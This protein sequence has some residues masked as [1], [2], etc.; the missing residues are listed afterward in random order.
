MASEHTILASD[1]RVIERFV[2]SRGD[3]IEPLLQI[4]N[5]P[6][7]LL[8]NPRERISSPQ[9][10]ALLD[11]LARA[12]PESQLGL[13]LATFHRITDTHVLGITAIS[14][15]T[16]LGA[17]RRLS[18]YQA[19]ISTQQPLKLLENS[20]TVTVTK[21]RVQG[22]QA[23]HIIQSFLFAVLLTAVREIS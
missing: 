4:A 16:T 19:L 10:G 2:L 9:V 22:E 7:A 20:N 13:E 17:L 1:L 11:E 5:I 18:K 14:S 12:Y 3:D 8:K 15:E 6:P 23:E 21:S